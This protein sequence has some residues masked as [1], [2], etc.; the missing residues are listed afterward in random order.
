[1]AIS[2]GNKRTA[3][4]WKRARGST[5]SATLV[6]AAGVCATCNGSEPA[7]PAVGGTPAA[8]AAASRS[9]LET[10]LEAWL[11]ICDWDAVPEKAQA[12]KAQDASACALGGAQS[13]RP[14]AAASAAACTTNTYGPKGDM[15][16]KARR[17]SASTSPTSGPKLVLTRFPTR[18]L[19]SWLLLLLKTSPTKASA[20]V[21]K[22]ASGLARGEPS[23]L[24][25]LLLL[26]LL[27]PP[28]VWPPSLLQLPWARE[29]GSGPAG[30]S[31]KLP[32]ELRRE[33]LTASP[34]SSKAVGERCLCCVAGVA[35]AAAPSCCSSWTSCGGSTSREVASAGRRALGCEDSGSVPNGYPE[36]VQR[37][38]IFQQ[39]PP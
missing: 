4:V 25:L 2:K 39:R 13:V 16:G 10:R 1:M 28:P 8:G 29:A 32:S 6:V 14:F 31:K 23:W 20:A 17:G 27:L 12:R 18:L 19:T 37:F 15:T 3:G 26:L 11:F 7:V 35:S 22:A 5:A 30:C 36:N 24:L 9:S 33:A 38:S 34:S 21:L